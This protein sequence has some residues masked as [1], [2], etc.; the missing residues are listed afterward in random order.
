M[1]YG[2]E[3]DRKMDENRFDQSRKALIDP[4]KRRD[5]LGA[6]SASAMA[7]LATLGLAE[8]GDAKKNNGGKN[9]NKNANQEHHRNRG[10][11]RQKGSTRPSSSAPRLRPHPTSAADLRTI[12][13]PIHRPV[14][15]ITHVFWA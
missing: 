10:H 1:R 13:T 9:K 14:A 2:S 6:I 11:R 15:Q 3:E 5:A 4:T 7:L 8:V 12:L